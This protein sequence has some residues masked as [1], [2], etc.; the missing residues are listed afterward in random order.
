MSPE[1]ALAASARDWP[2]RVHRHLLDHGGGTVV[3]RLM[4]PEQALDARF[5]VL[6]IDDI[7]SFLTPGLI[8]A[9]KQ[10]G[11]EVVGVFSPE[12]GSDAKR[13]L[14]E[15]GISDVIET[16]AAPEE[17]VDKAAGAMQHRFEPVQE[18]APSTSW[19]VGVV[20]VTDGVGATEIAVGLASG[21]PAA[22]RPCLVDLDPTWPSVA[23]RLDLPLH[24]N[25][26]SA[27]DAVMHGSAGSESS[28][29]LVGD[30]R[31]IGGVADQGSA[32]PVSRAA[33]EALLED[34]GRVSEVVVADLG[35]FER[36]IRGLVSRM[37]STILVG[38][39]DPVGVAR[40]LAV[41][42]RLLD[43]VEPEIVLLVVNQTSRNKYRQ[44]E[45]RHEIE[46]GIPHV[47]V[48]IVP[49]DRAVARAAW[50][51]QLVPRSQFRK[52]VRKMAALVG[53]RAVA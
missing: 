32:A 15:C 16:D 41:A 24:P 1:I 35:A 52:T 18:P 44:S 53:A 30:L 40:L 17:F 46:K 2:D 20:G 43:L 38:T 36:S 45:I 11:S 12:D 21:I 33:V 23:Q 7:C 10:A 25:L 34:A 13:R 6:L 27:V 26:R 31:V 14:L 5:D 9:V 28:A 49:F 42:E 51:G 19:T 47:P 39:G 37:N 3:G 48:I 22:A 50:E 29:H 8:A 4:G